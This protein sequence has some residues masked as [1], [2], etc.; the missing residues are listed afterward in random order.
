MFRRCILLL[1]DYNY[2][3]ISGSSLSIST[4]YSLWVIL[5]N[6]NLYMLLYHSHQ[7]LLLHHYYQIF[8]RIG[9]V[10][11]YYSNDSHNVHTEMEVISQEI[12]HQ[13]M[14]DFVGINLLFSFL[15]SSRRVCSSFSKQ[16]Q[17]CFYNNSSWWS[18]LRN[19]SQQTP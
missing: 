5:F 19:R 6:V 4:L 15:W 1:F 9:R 7:L 18:W 10:S 12:L 3:I 8:A 16:I 2:V 14:F 11:H 17:G 13:F